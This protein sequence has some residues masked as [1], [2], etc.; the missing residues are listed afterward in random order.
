MQDQPPWRRS[1]KKGCAPALGGRAIQQGFRR[2]AARAT[3]WP[4]P[5]TARAQGVSLSRGAPGNRRFAGWREWPRRAPQPS[6][7]PAGRRCSASR[8]GNRRRCGR[9]TPRRF[10]RT[11][12]PGRAPQSEG[13]AGEPVDYARREHTT[14]RGRSVKKRDDRANHASG[15]AHRILRT[16]VGA[17]PRG[18]WSSRRRL[19][20]ALALSLYA[21]LVAITPALHHD[22]AC[23]VKSPGHCDACLANPLASRTEPA[24]GLE[25]PPMRAAGETPVC[26]QPRE[27]R[28]PV[29]PA[30][31]RA[32]PA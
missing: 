16:M 20:A 9:R 3:E 32:P 17:R 24:A 12:R 29:A 30:S 6:P 14:A 4:R 21:L 18:G 5:W 26:A 25:A 7:W 27:H 28:A 10:P 19:L 22:L 2:G 1:A 15:A 23:H 31:G 13:S 11:P 8:R